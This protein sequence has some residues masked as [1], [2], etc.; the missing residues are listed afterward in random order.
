MAN[1]LDNLKKGKATQFKAGEEQAKIASEGGKKSAAARKAKSDLRQAAQDILD[2]IYTTKDKQG[3]ITGKKSGAELLIVNL[4][5]IASDK[6]N[7]NCISAMRLLIE[8]IGANRSPETIE[9]E[10]ATAALIQAKADMLTGAD[11]STLEKLDDIL[12]EMR[13]NADIKRKAK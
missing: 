11:T 10:K 2:N 7:K 6:S 8:L 5:G 13:D 1:K 9:I 4:F 3:N 12:K